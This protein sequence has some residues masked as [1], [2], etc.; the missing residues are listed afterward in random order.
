VAELS[1]RKQ[2]GAAQAALT[3]MEWAMEHAPIKQ[4]VLCISDD[5]DN[6]IETVQFNDKDWPDGGGVPAVKIMQMEHE[7][8]K[9][10]QMIVAIRLLTEETGVIF[11]H[12][13]LNAIAI[14]DVLKN[15]REFAPLDKTPIWIA[16]NFAAVP[17]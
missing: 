7:D 2:S 15:M 10:G 3:A 8:L 13:Y 6:T 4:I 11:A 9:T 14:K 1:R 16:V 17:E 12:P 5:T